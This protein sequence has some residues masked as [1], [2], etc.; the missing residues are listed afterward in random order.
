MSKLLR[1]SIVGWTLFLCAGSWAFAQEESS[2]RR[3]YATYCSGC[4]GTSGKGDGPAAKSLPV[5]P[6]DHT[7]GAMN[8]LNDQ[9][10]FEIIAKGGASVGRSAQMPAWGGVVKD[11]QIRAVVAYIRTLAA[12]K[13]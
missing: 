11:N 4:H 10:L 8:Q 7:R 12:E 2:G 6:A 5:R 9:Y 13:R 1:W 3:I